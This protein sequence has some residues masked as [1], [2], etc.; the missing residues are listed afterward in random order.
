MKTLLP[1]V[2]VLLI[3]AFGCDRDSGDVGDLSKIRVDWKDSIKVGMT[4]DEVEKLL[5]K[6]TEIRR[7]VEEYDVDPQNFMTSEELL[8]LDLVDS[9]IYRDKKYWPVPRK[10]HTIGQ[11]IYV[12]WVFSDHQIDTGYVI[13]NRKEWGKFSDTDVK[14]FVND[15][16]VDK[17]LFDQIGDYVHLS[18]TGDPISK[19]MWDRYKDSEDLT[20]LKPKGPVKAR[21]HIDRGETYRFVRDLENRKYYKEVSYFAVVFDASSG[22]V[23]R[24]GF[25]PFDIIGLN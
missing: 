7:G 25:H 19:S 16:I 20:G 2:I 15:Q 1:S 12:T 22:R 4:Y 18:P 5:G 11:L 3:L 6:P 14:Y 21:K 17:W 23:V 13:F 9:L 10:L 8:A 24:S